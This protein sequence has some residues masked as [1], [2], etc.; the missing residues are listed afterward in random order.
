[1][2]QLVVVQGPDTLTVQRV[3]ERLLFVFESVCGLQPTDQLLHD[4]TA[5]AKFPRLR[6][7]EIPIA[8]AADSSGTWICTAG[9]AFWRGRS[10]ADA[11]TE[12]A[13]RWNRLR[14]EV[15]SR[16]L[17]EADGPFVLAA[18]AGSPDGGVLVAT[19]R[20]GTL[21]AY[22]ATADSCT[23]L[24]TSSLVLAAW[25]RPEWQ[26]DSCREFLS[27]GTVFGQR[28]LF[29][30]IEKLGPA[31]IFELRN[32]RLNP[33]SRYWDLAQVMTSRST[34]CK[35]IPAIAEALTSSLRMIT[36]SFPNALFDLTGGFDSRIVAGAMLKVH[37]GFS[38]VVVG[39]PENA[40]V[41]I[42]GEIAAV[43]RLRHQRVESGPDEMES[44]LRALAV[45]DGECDLVDYSRTMRVHECLAP[46]YDASVNGSN[47][48]IAKG[49]WWELLFPYTGRNGHFDEKK[50]AAKRFAEGTDATELLSMK[51]GT[52]L[53][54]HFAELIRE[55]GRGFEHHPNTAKMDNIYLTL[56]MQQWQGRIASATSR[57]WPCVSPFMWRQP[58]ELILATPPAARVRHRLSRRI[59]EHLNPELA[60][61]PMEQG[62]PAL[63][64]RLNTAHR[65]GPLLREIAG[66][67]MSRIP[68][69]M[70]TAV[71]T[72]K[73]QKTIWNDQGLRELMQPGHMVTSDLYRHTTLAELL[74]PPFRQQDLLNR[75]VTLELLGRRLRVAG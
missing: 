20:L 35:T 5:V 24:C 28:S 41:K 10:S 6:K 2:S 23:V 3:F 50:L 34:D 51:F 58:M 42:A 30:G 66:K 45:C 27:T 43:M 32:G 19:D 55:A 72:L 21:H 49:Y 38:T 44:L 71:L 68:R 67:A 33:R 9:T 17:Q 63:P 8:R 31:Q 47:G 7:H 75:V 26:A 39:S 29:R 46:L 15:M 37:S 54:D 18:G 60:A 70:N 13:T 11:L 74:R 22:T 65:F 64:L 61:L 62:Y 12:L 40:D 48:E 14:P 69:P 57:I 56:R 73:S 16:D 36:S 52:T 59:I 4:G 25:L 1:M 53:T